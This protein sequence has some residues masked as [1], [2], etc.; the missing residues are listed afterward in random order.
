MS[1]V[2][3]CSWK[4]VDRVNNSFLINRSTHRVEKGPEPWAVNNNIP[5]LVGNQHLGVILLGRPSHARELWPP[6]LGHYGEWV[7]PHD[8][9]VVRKVLVMLH[10][11][12]RCFYT[13]GNFMWEGELLTQSAE[14]ILSQ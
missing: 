8:V 10:F 9:L 13:A 2:F 6:S 14:D 12:E 5:D 3:V 1:A 11:G 7:V 4:E